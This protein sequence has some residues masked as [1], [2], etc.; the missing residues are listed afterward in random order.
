MKHVD[1]RR[2]LTA[3]STIVALTLLGCAGGTSSQGGFGGGMMGGGHGNG[4]M[5]G[6]GGPSLLV[7][8]LVAG[9]VAWFVVRGRNQR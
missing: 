3:A 7:V 2:I 5:G 1:I 8:I 4:W 9:L 6:Y